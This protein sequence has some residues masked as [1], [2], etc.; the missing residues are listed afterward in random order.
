LPFTTRT[1]GSDVELIARGCVSLSNDVAGNNKKTCSGNR[2]LLDEISSVV[3][4]WHDYGFMLR[5]MLNV[6]KNCDSFM[7]KV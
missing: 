6:S 1:N 4:F 3:L 7:M 2:A 5:L